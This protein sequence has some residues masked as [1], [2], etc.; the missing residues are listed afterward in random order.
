MLMRL[1]TAM[2]VVSQHA[3][4]FRRA[5][6]ARDEVAMKRAIFGRVVV[7]RRQH[8]VNTEAGH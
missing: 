6:N 1:G 4:E 7:K 3:L 5:G 2:V 8:P